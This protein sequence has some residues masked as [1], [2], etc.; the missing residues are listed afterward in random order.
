MSVCVC[1]RAFTPTN[2]R[3]H[4]ICPSVCLPT[5]VRPGTVRHVSVSVTASC[6]CNRAVAVIR[7]RSCLWLASPSGSMFHFIELTSKNSVLSGREPYPRYPCRAV[8]KQ[9]DVKCGWQREHPCNSPL[10]IESDVTP[11]NIGDYEAAKPCN[12][13]NAFE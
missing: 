5:S 13:L 8:V 12:A 2:P 9:L 6:M 4:S 7:R 10:E 3:V 1:K 11:F